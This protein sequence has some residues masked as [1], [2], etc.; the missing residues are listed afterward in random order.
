MSIYKLDGD[1]E[2]QVDDPIERIK[3]LRSARAKKV[4]TRA[5]A[6]MGIA[7][8]GVFL[9]AILNS[10]GVIVC[11]K[12]HL[13]DTSFAQRVCAVWFCLLFATFPIGMLAALRAKLSDFI[14]EEARTP[15]MLIGVIGLGVLF[16]AA[17]DFFPRPY[18]GTNMPV[19]WHFVGGW[20]LVLW[21]IVFRK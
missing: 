16:Y 14:S 15:C 19:N 1:Q 20:C 6:A 18:T 7:I 2:I 13:P 9:M 17:A 12:T 8:A 21:G 10:T 5:G 11:T 3:S 4:Q